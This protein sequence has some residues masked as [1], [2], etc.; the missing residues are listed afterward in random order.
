MRVILTDNQDVELGNRTM[1]VK[2]KYNLEYMWVN[3]FTVDRMSAGYRTIPKI[4]T[5]YASNKMQW[6]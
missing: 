2:C 1:H 3:L 6:T 4:T 5:I